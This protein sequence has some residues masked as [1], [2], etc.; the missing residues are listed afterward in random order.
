MADQY[1]ALVVVAPLLG[2]CLAAISGWLRRE[3]CFSLALAA[4]AVSL[5]SSLGMLIQVIDS[6]PILYRL[7][8]WDPPM[9]IAYR[10]DLLNAPVLV[11]VSIAALINLV[12]ARAAIVRDMADRLGSVYALYTLATAGMLGMVA[13][14]DA[15][16]LYVLLEITSLTGYA[17]IAVGSARACRTSLN[18]LFLGTIGASLYLLGVGYLYAAT[19]TLNMADLAA[20]LPLAPAGA[21]VT[22]AMG[23]ILVGVW[24]KMA[25]FPLHGWLP[26][27]YSAAPSATAGLLAPLTTKVMVYVMIRMMLS[28]FGP[29]YV[30]SR[31]VLSQVVVGVAT[32][33]I[34]YGAAAALAQRDLRR[35]L[36]YIIVAEVGYMVGG[37]WLGN[38]TGMTGA[39]LHLLNDALMTLCVFLAAASIDFRQGG[40]GFEKLRG[41][42]RTMPWTMAALVA[43]A[44]SII[45]VPPSG[46]FFSK[47]YLISGAVEAGSYHFAAALLISSLVSVVLFFRVF[48]LAYYGAEDGHGHGH[49]GGQD[50]APAVMAEAPLGMV[51][52]LMFTAA[53]LLAVGL[54]SGPLVARIIAPAVAG[55]WPPG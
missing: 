25:L 4:L 16:N 47:W 22:A 27:A 20:R 52:P 49:G 51:A 40:L 18:Y 7:S 39:V 50:H 53:L 42:F 8:G 34:L 48:E 30:F 1:P 11:V 41:L 14:G 38:R 2:A 44:L 55:F 24:L 3:L 28:V 32:A 5:G 9:G 19:G 17:L 37:A 15:F 43:G 6:G 23:V 54:L 13:T 12:S 46:G 10:I 45:G 36:A 26:G 31:D 35:M 33:A 21:A 29:E